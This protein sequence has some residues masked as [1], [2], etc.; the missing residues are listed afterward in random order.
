MDISSFADQY[1]VRLGPEH[2]RALAF[3]LGFWPDHKGNKAALI[4]EII[5]DWEQWA[6]RGRG[7]TAQ[8]IYQATLT[9]KVVCAAY[10]GEDPEIVEREYTFDVWSTEFEKSIRGEGENPFD[11]FIEVE[12]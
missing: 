5:R 9:R 2:K 11:I 8:V 7:K 6:N 12:K 1:A 10:R 3:A 4:R